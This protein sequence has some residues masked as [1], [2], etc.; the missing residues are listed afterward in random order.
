VRNQPRYYYGNLC[1]K[2]GP[3]NYKGLDMGMQL[4]W[5]KEVFAQFNQRPPAHQ[6]GILSTGWGGI[7]HLVVECAL[8]FVDL[9]PKPFLGFFFFCCMFSFP[10]LRSP[11]RL[12]TTYLLGPTY[13]WKTNFPPLTYL[14]DQHPL[15]PPKLVTSFLLTYLPSLFPTYLPTYLPTY[16]TLT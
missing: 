14:L 5:V 16:P 7:S 9:N 12:H 10:T 8:T 2:H 13:Q 1:L 4:L 11:A 3:I 6:L 15:F